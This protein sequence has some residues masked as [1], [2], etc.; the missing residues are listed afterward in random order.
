MMAGL[1]EKIT[2]LQVNYDKMTIIM[3]ER[4]RSR[5]SEARG[6]EYEFH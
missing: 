6:A 3:K 4:K 2:K 1:N 5:P